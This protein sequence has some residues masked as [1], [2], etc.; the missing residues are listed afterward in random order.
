[1]RRGAR[2]PTVAGMPSRNPTT[3]LVETYVP[4]LDEATAVALSARLRAT[5]A[6]L[7]RE[8]LALRWLRSFALVGE[9]TYM[10]MLTAMDA[11]DIVLVNRRA[12]I[13]FD[14]MA[15]VLPGEASGA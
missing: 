3:Y 7:Q 14:H 11:D 5:I 8:G 15:E 9:E 10:W 4:K 6:E 1:M 2:R 12:G 13:T